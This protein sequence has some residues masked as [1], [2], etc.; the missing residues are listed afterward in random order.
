[1]RGWK[2]IKGW[3]T[4]NHPSIKE[5][6]NIEYIDTDNYIYGQSLMHI[7]YLEQQR[8]GQARI[9]AYR[10]EE[11]ERRMNWREAMREGFPSDAEERAGWRPEA[12][13][14][15]EGERIPLS[16]SHTIRD[17]LEERDR[18]E[19]R[20]IEIDL[21]IRADSTDDV[22]QREIRRE[23]RRQE[24]QRLEEAYR[25][26]TERMTRDRDLGQETEPRPQ[27]RPNHPTIDETTSAIWE[28]KRERINISDVFNRR[29]HDCKYY[30]F[31]GKKTAII[32]PDYP[33]E[34]ICKECLETRD[35]HER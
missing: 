26:G 27:R 25:Y 32:H 31:C 6:T 14:L 13:W 17:G 35:K 7:D 1:M 8:M 18:I 22:V 3:L 15:R 23:T 10:E 11:A 33:Q 29:T 20:Q 30:G 34:Y 9:E 21:F 28:I 19:Q 5:E 12:D 16:E 24:N 4:G 2:K